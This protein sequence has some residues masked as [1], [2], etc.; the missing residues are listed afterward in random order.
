MWGLLKTGSVPP[1]A[2][3]EHI[4]MFSAYFQ[5]V[6]QVEQYIMDSNSA[7][8]ISQDDILTLKNARSGKTKVGNSLV[9][10]DDG[11]ISYIHAYL[12]KAGIRC[13]GPNLDEGPESLFNAACRIS[14]LISFQ[15]IAISGG[16]NFLNFNPKYKDDMLLLIRAYNHYVHHVLAQKY[17]TE[18][19]MVGKNQQA[20]ET[21]NASRNRTRVSTSDSTLQCGG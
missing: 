3:P 21:H 7:A 15:Q 4:R 5:T 16:Y 12:A 10:I 19:K 8:L 13:W 20:I 2:D 14:A 18:C 17:H 6:N 11:H 1:R 9:H